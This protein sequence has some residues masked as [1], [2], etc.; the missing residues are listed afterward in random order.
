MMTTLFVSAGM[1]TTNK[2]RNPLGKHHRYLNH[3]LLGLASA[4]GVREFG[5]V[6][7]H[8]GFS[9]PDLFAKRL[10]A[11]HETVRVVLLSVTSSLCLEWARVFTETLKSIAEDLLIVMGG[12]WVLQGDISWVRSMMGAVNVFHRGMAEDGISALLEDLHSGRYSPANATEIGSDSDRAAWVSDVNYELLVGFREYS[13]SLEVSRGCGMDC[14]FCPERGGKRT[15][16]R[17]PSETVEAALRIAEQYGDD[18]LRFYFEAASFSPTEHWAHRFERAYE[19]TLGGFSWRCEARVDSALSRLLEPL[20]RAGLRIVDVGLESASHRQLM[21]MRKTD[22]PAGYLSCASRFLERA[23]DAGVWV[24][25]NLMPYIGETHATFMETSDWL[26]DHRNL[27][28]GVSVAPY[29]AYRSNRGTAEVMKEAAHLG[30]GLKDVESFE[31]PGFSTVH[32]SREIDSD[33]AFALSTELAR[34]LME[35]KDY[36]EL[37]SHGYFPRDWCFDAFLTEARAVPPS[38]LPFSLPEAAVAEHNEGIHTDTE[39]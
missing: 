9:P 13:P 12:R 1:T 37:K 26:A 7:I 2:G 3:G 19:A 30:G 31:W 5:P 35:A 17:A 28:K 22:D 18:H 27:I 23:A 4:H 8:G 38:D 25:L 39:N 24:K 15:A 14:A 32:L 16:L 33:G 21:R 34:N 10:L 11:E 6:V 20:G 36:F 29:M